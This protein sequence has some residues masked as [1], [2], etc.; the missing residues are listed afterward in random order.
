MWLDNSETGD[1]FL[2]HEAYEDH[3]FSPYSIV[4][5][6]RVNVSSDDKELKWYQLSQEEVD[7]NERMLKGGD[8]SDIESDA[9]SVGKD[10]TSDDVLQYEVGTRCNTLESNLRCKVFYSWDHTAKFTSIL[11]RYI[12]ISFFF[13]FP[14]IYDLH[15]SATF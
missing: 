8:D 6:V 5:C 2:F 11:S 14:R 7:R 1:M 10:A 3:R 12:L 9:E 13:C 15:L 4:V